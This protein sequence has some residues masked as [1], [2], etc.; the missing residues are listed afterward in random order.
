MARIPLILHV[1]DN[2]D[3]RLL[4]ARA[5]KHSRLSGVLKGVGSAEEALLVLNRTGPF[6]QLPRPSLIILDLGLPQ[7][8]GRDFLALVRKQLRFKGI[9]IIVLSGSENYLDIQHCRELQVVEYL[10]KVTGMDE[11]VELIATFD[12]WLVG[13]SSGMSGRTLTPP[14]EP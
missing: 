1:D 10:V 12:R 6:A 9:P 3:D 8:D 5:F 2:E 13:S 11:L 4:F 14:P 7:L